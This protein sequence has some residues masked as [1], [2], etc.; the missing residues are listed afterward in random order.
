MANYW[1]KR[2][3]AELSTEA[4]DLAKRGLVYLMHRRFTVPASSSVSFVMETNGKEVQFEFYDITSDSARVYAELIEEPTYSLA[5]ASFSGY[6]LNRTFSDAHTVTLYSASAV[7]GGVA[8]AS[9]LL[10]NTSKAGGSLANNK[11]HILKGNASYVMTFLNLDNQSTECHLN[12]GWSEDEPDRYD[13]VTEGINS[14]GV[15]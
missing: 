13:L 6:N 2:A 3:Y 14:G 7:S 9:E 12:L 11:V 8:V 10:G 4:G 1:Q 15:T 5:S